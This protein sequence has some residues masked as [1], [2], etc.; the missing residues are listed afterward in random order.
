MPR[1]RRADRG[2]AASAVKTGPGLEN[3][4]PGQPGPRVR[5]PP[6][7]LNPRRR[8][9]FG[10][11]GGPDGRLN[12]PPESDTSRQ[13]PARGGLRP[14]DVGLMWVPRTGASKMA[15]PPRLTP[16]TRDCSPPT[17][18]GAGARASLAGFETAGPDWTRI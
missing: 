1:D 3:R 6:S 4:W 15:D 12:D 2:L 17:C 18:A 5:T 16:S 9:E 13:R 7:P 8:A 10:L 11:S 14:G